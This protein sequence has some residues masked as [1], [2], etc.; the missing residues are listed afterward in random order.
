MNA[1]TRHGIV[2]TPVGNL[3]LVASDDALTGLYFARHWPR[4]DTGSFGERVPAQTD[5][6]LSEVA[7]QLAGYFAGERTSFD[8]PIT[9]RGDA[10]QEQV[11]SLLREI[12]FG[13]TATYGELA[14]RYGDRSLARDI[15]QAIGQNPL[16][17]VVPCHR[18]VGKDGTLVGYA[19]GLERKRALLEIE[20]W[21]LQPKSGHANLRDLTIGRDTPTQQI[22][23][24]SDELLA[25]IAG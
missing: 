22:P 23:M 11:W 9:T 25:G 17:I 20:G 3:T 21:H 4:P 18:V 14:R 24:L 15:G 13:E 7:R 16:S 8:I 12:P 2:L 19:G 10:F 5:T 6:L 1:Y